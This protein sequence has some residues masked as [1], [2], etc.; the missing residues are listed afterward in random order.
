ML[1]IYRPA[2][3]D[4]CCNTVAAGQSCYGTPKR[5]AVQQNAAACGH[6]SGA[7]WHYL[8]MSLTYMQTFYDAQCAVSISMLSQAL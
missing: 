8:R 3:N 7:A 6:A 4:H 5:H 2:N 1:S